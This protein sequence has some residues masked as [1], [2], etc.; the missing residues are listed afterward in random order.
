M[1][2]IVA[3]IEADIISYCN[4]FRRRNRSTDDVYEELIKGER[5]G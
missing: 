4:T 2:N 5:R 3:L 1:L